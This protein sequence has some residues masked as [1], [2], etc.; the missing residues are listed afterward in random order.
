VHRHQDGRLAGQ[1]GLRASGHPGVGDDHVNPR[2]E[3]L[4]D[5]E[6]VQRDCKQQRIGPDE[7]VGQGRGQRL[8]GLLLVRA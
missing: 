1:D 8:R 2:L 6:V 7:L 3:V 4:Q 5:A